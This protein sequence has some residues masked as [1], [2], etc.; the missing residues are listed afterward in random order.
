MVS[1]SYTCSA[2]RALTCRY[3]EGARPP[4]EIKLAGSSAPLP[5]PEQVAEE[6]SK[7]KLQM[8]EA[9]VVLS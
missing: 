8:A 4:P 2:W 9:Q 6:A 7:A 1:S 3:L 5:K